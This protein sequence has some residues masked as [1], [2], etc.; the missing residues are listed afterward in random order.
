MSWLD[1]VKARLFK[2]DNIE[3]E[4]V[5]PVVRRDAEPTVLKVNTEHVENAPCMPER[6]LFVCSGNICRSAYGAVKL[7]QLLKG[8]GLSMRI[9][10]AGTLRLVGRAA[11]PEMIASA[12][13]RGLDLTHH[14]SSALSKPLVEAAD[15]IF[16]MAH[17]HRL[18]IERI[19]PDCSPRIVMMGQFLTH[20]KAEILDPM[21]CA[22]QIYR[23]VANEIDEALENW[24]HA[25]EKTNKG[26]V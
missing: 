1:R 13:E 7:E 26:D 19:C 3:P 5:M 24:L 20:P 9:A 17:E 11:A 4:G 22:P 8:R 16:A 23:E 10:S 25:V 14:R 21:G 18:E 15:V 2:F 12:D 6:V